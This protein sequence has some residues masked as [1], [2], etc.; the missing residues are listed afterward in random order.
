MAG[1]SCKARNTFVRHDT[2]DHAVLRVWDWLLSRLTATMTAQNSMS[3][4]QAAATKSQAVGFVGQ[5]CAA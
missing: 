1:Q 3:G 4:L 5:L 2:V